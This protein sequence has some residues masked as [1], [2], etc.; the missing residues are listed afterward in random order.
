V[1]LE[2]RGVG[3]A[4]YVNHISLL[5]KQRSESLVPSLSGSLD[6]P[7]CHSQPRERKGEEH[8][9]LFKIVTDI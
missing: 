7:F 2:T 5:Q 8:L 4:S 1:R 9:Q 6:F 3:F